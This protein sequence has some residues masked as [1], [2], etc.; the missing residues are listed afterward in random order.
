MVVSKILELTPAARLTEFFIFVREFAIDALNDGALRETI[1]TNRFGIHGLFLVEVREHTPCGGR[2][3]RLA[4]PC[5]EYST[6]VRES[7]LRPR[8]SH[9][10]VFKSRNLAEAADIDHHSPRVCQEAGLKSSS[11]CDD[12]NRLVWGGPFVRSFYSTSLQRHLQ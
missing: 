8:I 10:R 4:V 12:A 2:S 3:S 1:W 11:H 6:T 9:A 5:H 7:R